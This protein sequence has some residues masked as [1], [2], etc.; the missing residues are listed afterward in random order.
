MDHH[1]SG[2]HC[3]IRGTGEALHEVAFW[4]V[5][6]GEEAQRRIRLLLDTGGPLLGNASVTWGPFKGKVKSDIIGE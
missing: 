3:G 2:S 4:A 5:D 1:P 6:T